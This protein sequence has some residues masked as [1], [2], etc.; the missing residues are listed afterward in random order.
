[1]TRRLLVTAL[2][3]WSLFTEQSA[4]ADTDVSAEA[5]F[6]DPRVQEARMSPDGSIVLMEVE[7]SGV[8][9]IEAV[10]PEQMKAQ[11]LNRLDDG[12]VL[13][14][15][16]W[17]GNRAFM[18]DVYV[19]GAK[20]SYR[21]I[22]RFDVEDGEITDLDVQNFNLA[23]QL[24][25]PLP[26]DDEFMLLQVDAR[27][28]EVSYHGIYK[29]PLNRRGRITRHLVKRYRADVEL[30]A[31]GIA[32]TDRSHEIRF[33]FGEEKT[34][35]QST[36]A[37]MDSKGE[38]SDAEVTYH[39]IYYREPGGPWK[40][41]AEVDGRFFYGVVDVA[42]DNRSLIL[43]TDAVEDV[44]TVQLFDP[45][46]GE[47]T[48][49]L[50][51]FDGYD[52]VSARTDEDGRLETAYYYDE[53]RLTARH[54]NE[55]REL[56]KSLLEDA[57]GGQN[58][59]VYLVNKARGK[60]RFLAWVYGGTE[61][62]HF[63]YYDRTERSLLDIGASR[64]WL[65]GKLSGNV[66][67]ISAV[68]DDDLPLEGYLTLPANTPENARLPMVVIPHGGPMSVRSD[69]GFNATAQYFAALGLAVFEPN[70][71]GSS[72]FGRRFVEEGKG[73][74]GTGIEDDIDRLVSAVIEDQP[75]DPERICVY[76]SS[77]GG[78]SAL[79]A[80]LRNPERYRCSASFA[81]PTDL[82][83][84]FTA[85]DWAYTDAVDDAIEWY[86]HPEK[87]AEDLHAR[88]PVYQAARF[89]TPLLIA[90]GTEDYRVDF[91]HFRRLTRMLDHF[92]IAYEGLVLDGVGHG[93]DSWKARAEFHEQIG[94][95]LL[96]HLSR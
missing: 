22:A 68:A 85:S 86:G 39:Q 91:E 92:D 53:G 52:V 65:R 90:H 40:R 94:R 78:Y 96:R 46:T 30:P 67:T 66:R 32:I 58:N 27:H 35:P 51:Q 37:S 23:A 33:V 44:S 12:V 55:L 50:A 18:L 83:L 29:Y 42:E 15:I 47:F 25:D 17:L 4:M 73:Q 64:P 19:P 34:R 75:I 14:R 31:R 88:S 79:M 84:S 38:T 28:V 1:M 72:G 26:D 5:Y 69:S 74:L 56:E 36:E 76:G 82:Q 20:S 70:Y 77:Y 10:M 54:M 16:R 57:V 62:G 61:S 41:G 24:I 63:Y 89:S 71:R 49:T 59:H 8:R 87:D 45:V 43:V 95:F 80:G 21:L 2:V 93:F 3:L 6:K 11:A 60:D 48:K 81:G 7:E 13:E 9:Y